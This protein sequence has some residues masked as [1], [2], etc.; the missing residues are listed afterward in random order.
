MKIK[1]SAVRAL[2]RFVSNGVKFQKYN[3]HQGKC[4]STDAAIPC[5]TMVFFDPE[6][7]VVTINDNQ[8]V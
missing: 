2:D 5:G 3:A 6:K 4:L 7:I 1:F 8:D